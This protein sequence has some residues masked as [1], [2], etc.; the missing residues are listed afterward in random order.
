MLSPY[1]MRLCEDDAGIPDLDVD[2]LASP[3][4]WQQVCVEEGFTEFAPTCF[5]ARYDVPG[6]ICG[7]IVIVNYVPREN[8]LVVAV[9]DAGTGEHTEGAKFKGTDCARSLR[10]CLRRIKRE[11]AAK[12]AIIPVSEALEDNGDPQYLPSKE[13]PDPATEP[14]AADQIPDLDMDAITEPSGPKAFR[15]YPHDLYSDLTRKLRGRPSKKVA[16]NTYIKDL[17]AGHLGVL[18]HSTYV[19]DVDIN[20]NITF[21]TGGWYTKLTRERIEDH[22]KGGWHIFTLK[23]EW[24]WYNGATGE[25][26]AGK[27]DFRIPF[28]SDDTIDA[29]GTLR[30]AG[31]VELIPR[32]RTRR[33]Q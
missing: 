27:S 18:V 5:S 23:G 26:M 3:Q 1:V 19:I 22:N 6:D 9:G 24:Y 7:A 16:N 21:D 2:A 11:L 12:G 33:P 28:S 4:D 17:G 15:G 14:E 13:L 30:I 31:T 10:R 8:N 20:N 25:G 32:R 29:N